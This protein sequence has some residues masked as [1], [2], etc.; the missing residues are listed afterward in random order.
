MTLQV[1]CRKLTCLVLRMEEFAIENG[2]GVNSFFTR[3]VT[4]VGSPNS[5]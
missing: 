4:N 2:N 3:K 5:S 1:L